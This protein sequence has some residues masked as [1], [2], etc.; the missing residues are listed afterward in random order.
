MKVILIQKIDFGLAN[1]KD[2]SSE[3]VSPQEDRRKKI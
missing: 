3:I 1:L 2:K